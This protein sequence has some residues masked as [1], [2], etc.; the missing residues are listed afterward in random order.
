MHSLSAGD[1]TTTTT[2]MYRRMILVSQTVLQQS[3]F[4][5]ISFLI[6]PCLRSAFRRERIS[7]YYLLVRENVSSLIFPVLFSRRVF[8]QLDPS[9]QEYTK[10]FFLFI[11]VEYNFKVSRKLSDFLEPPPQPQPHRFH[12]FPAILL[13]TL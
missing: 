12:I 11:K 2:T 8:R 13:W 3:S 1:P 4:S 6:F 9:P 7:V 5:P 10:F